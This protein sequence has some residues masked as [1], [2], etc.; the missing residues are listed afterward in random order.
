MVSL[1]DSLVS[2]SARKLPLKVR[3]DLTAQR[4]HYLG[5]SYWVLKE[6]IGAKYF[7]F[8][9][10]EYA[11]LQKFDGFHS[12]DDIKEEFE[13]EFPPQK[14]TLEELQNFLGQLHQ[15]GLIV[16]STPNQGPELLKRRS[17]RKRQELF[18]KYSN[19]LALRF[20]GIDPDVMLT[21]L[22]PYISWLF[23]PFIV[24]CCLI[25]C[26]SAASLVL[27][28]FDT[29]RSKLPEF[30]T[31][32]SPLNLLLM[33]IT[34][35]GTKVLHEL[36]HGFFAKHFKSECHEMGLMFLVLTPC[37]Y[38]NVSDSWLLPNKWH[39]MAIGIAGVYVECI[40]ASVCTFIWW[41]SQ[42]GLL[43]YL[44]LNIM[45]VSSVSTIV[46]NINPLLR[47]DGYYILA[48]YLEI[49]NLRQKATKIFGRLCQKWLLGMEV[50]D[51]PFLPKSNLVMFALFT[52]AS[53]F[54][55]WFIMVSIL[56]FIF[57][58]FEPYGVKIL[59]QMLAVLSVGTMLG[60][61]IYQ[62]GKFFWVPGRIYKVKKWRFYLSLS[63]FIAILGFLCF[64]PL[65]YTVLA[66]TVIE[67]RAADSSQVYVPDIRGG[68]R[69]VEV[70]VLPGQFVR[71]GD[72]IGKLEN[73]PLLSETASNEGRVQELE[74]EIK[75]LM[76]TRL[77]RS[78][79]VLRIG[80]V[81]ESLKAT[82]D[83]LKNLYRDVHDLT[84][85]APVDG[86]VVP[87]PWKPYQ[88]PPNDQLPQWWGSPLDK[89]NL[90]AAYEPGTMIC[91]IGDPKRLEA[92]LVVDQSK[93]GFLKTGQ[94]VT[95]KLNEFPDRVFTGT[96]SEIE[97]QAVQS[98]D[99]QLSTKAGGD[100]PTT[101]KRDGS[102][103]PNSASYRVRMLLDNPDLSIRV[104]MTGTAKVRVEPLTL[105]WRVWL[106]INET[107]NFKM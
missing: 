82:Q 24:I 5:R 55:R 64:C 14:V 79:A 77:Y 90:G 39:R 13:E 74:Q 37:L 67:L 72:V 8:Q 97:K 68:C 104:G 41:F 4:Q 34:L 43:N 25:L 58:V 18:Q 49:P 70:N 57:R 94:E 103:E 61:P 6:P 11:I 32:F 28:N 35:A 9:E 99:V 52:V 54:Y 21:E 87:P 96:V 20:K 45:F 89:E 66:P 65:P 19:V 107:F 33:S 44:A 38:M 27:V 73:L 12:L 60:M 100:V 26:L 80:P 59:G 36:G 95:V 10:E 71:K 17:K 75:T 23:H 31:F 63:V 2:S 7:R 78:D 3:P 91:S 40:L 15:S 47:Y 106:F 88:A 76:Q 85:T 83:L 93:T 48:D 51:D 50:Q 102:E 86:V 84:L 42:P 30:H 98:L 56:F 105:V 101:T 1:R 62:V 29:F 46:F 69:L 22:Y 16:A 53:F 92:V 81:Q